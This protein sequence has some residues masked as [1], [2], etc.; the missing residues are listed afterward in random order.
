MSRLTSSDLEAL[1]AGRALPR[2]TF[3]ALLADPQACAEL[4]RLAQVSDLL[5]PELPDPSDPLLDLPVGLDEIAR[6]VDGKL[7]PGPRHD[8]VARVVDEYLP[9]PLVDPEAGT[10]MEF[11][12]PGETR[13]EFR[14]PDGA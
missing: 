5:G 13:I 7:P 11:D 9:P 2:D 10:V 3:L 1:A 14:K 4:E 8:E 6:F 12:D